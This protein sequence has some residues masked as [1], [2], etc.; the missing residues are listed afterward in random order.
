MFHL[1]PE[2]SPILPLGTISALYDQAIQPGTLKQTWIF[3][4]RP[5]I[6]SVFYPVSQQRCF[7]ITRR[8]SEHAGG[9]ERFSKT[10]SPCQLMCASPG[11]GM[12]QEETAGW[13]VDP[14]RGSEMG[15]KG[16]GVSL[17]KEDSIFQSICRGKKHICCTERALFWQ[18]EWSSWRSPTQI[19]PWKGCQWRVFEWAQAWLNTKSYYSSTSPSLCTISIAGNRSIKPQGRE[20]AS[21]SYTRQCLIPYTCFCTRACMRYPQHLETCCPGDHCLFRCV[22]RET[23]TRMEGENNCWNFFKNKSICYSSSQTSMGWWQS[24]VGLM[25][26]IKQ[27]C[28]G[29]V[30]FI[31]FAIVLLI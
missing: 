22:V 17:L 13:I 24:P 23:W 27:I 29:R 20:Q 1:L 10:Q 12:G 8:S 9:S 7:V 5:L 14:G 19:L 2:L 21:G 6:A 25:L 28:S 3:T 26:P 30:G 16:G 15:G 18:G 11:V 31:D 4:I